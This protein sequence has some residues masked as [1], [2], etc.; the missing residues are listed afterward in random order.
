MRMNRFAV[1][2][3]L[4]KA[5]ALGQ[6]GQ[7]TFEFHSGFWVN[8]HH[9]L[10]NTSAGK[11]VGRAPNLSAFSPAETAAWNDAV[12]Y[13]DRN[14]VDHDF[15]E[16]SMIRINSALAAAA[17]KAS[18]RG[19][20]VP[21]P[22]IRVLEEAAPVY[23][24]RLWEDHD[25]KNREWIDQVSPLIAKYESILKPALA[26]AYDSPWPRERIRVEMS[27]YTTGASAYTSIGPTLVTISSWSQRNQGPAGLETIFHEAGHGLVQKIRDEISAAEKRSGRKLAHDDL[28]HAM[29]F[30]TT[31][32]IVR[33]QVPEITPYALKYGMWEHNWPD[34]LPVLD[35]DWQPFL[36]GKARFKEAID[37][38][39]ADSN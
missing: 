22:L 39:V 34:T 12:A 30:Y 25:R 24:A 8:L 1:L 14:L 26:H 31:G 9:T 36:D 6:A 3:L 11:K 27:Y 13:Y 19:S 29:M 5:A 10:Y 23:R 18:L 17:D 35:K 2:F 4:M 21:A 20:D 16:Y 7:T 32:T 15:L 38:V 37:R 28:W 33:Q